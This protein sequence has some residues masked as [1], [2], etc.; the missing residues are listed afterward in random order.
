V[1]TTIDQATGTKTGKEPLATLA[2]L[3]RNVRTGG[4]WFGQNAVPA[5]AGPAPT[6]LRLGDVC[7][8]DA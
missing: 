7:L 8:L 5:L 1:V 2:R 6:L 4:V 3:R